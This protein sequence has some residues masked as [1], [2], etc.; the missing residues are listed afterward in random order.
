MHSDVRVDILEEEL[1]DY[2]SAL[3]DLSWTTA[4]VAAVVKEFK[5][6]TKSKNILKIVKEC[7]EKVS[8]ET[9]RAVSQ[10][11]FFGALLSTDKLSR[12]IKI[13]VQIGLIN[14]IGKIYETLKTLLTV[15]GVLFLAQHKWRTA[16]SGGK[17]SPTWTSLVIMSSLVTALTTSKFIQVAFCRAERMRDETEKLDLETKCACSPSRCGL[18][19]GAPFSRKQ[20]RSQPGADP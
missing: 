15:L 4:T 19:S 20:S 7:D 17:D 9:T 14:L 12:K 6:T 10:L 16:Q 2:R 11:D 3:D 18:G 5:F 1:D 8:A 13:Y